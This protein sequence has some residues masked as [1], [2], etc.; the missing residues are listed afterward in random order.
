M[1]SEAHVRGTDP[2]RW[3]LTLGSLC[4]ACLCSRCPWVTRQHPISL[5]TSIFPI[6]QMEG[7]DELRTYPARRSTGDLGL[8]AENPHWLR[9]Q[10]KRL[11][12]LKVRV[13]T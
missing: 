7:S 9:G 5:W 10:S 1:G 12:S 4:P 2:A 13:H 8:R 3:E 6:C 11:T